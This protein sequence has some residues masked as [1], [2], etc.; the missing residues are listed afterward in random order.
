M[1]RCRIT[2]EQSDLRSCLPVLSSRVEAWLLTE[3]TGVDALLIH[4]QPSKSSR[5]DSP[6]NAS[7]VSQVH[8]L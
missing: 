5:R 6:T 3:Y 4:L 8:S 2:G 1:F 7:A